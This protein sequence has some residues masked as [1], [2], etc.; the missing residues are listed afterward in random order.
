MLEPGA[1]FFMLDMGGGWERVCYQPRFPAGAKT[2]DVFPSAVSAR[3]FG[4]GGYLTGTAAGKQ[5]PSVL[6]LEMSRWHSCIYYSIPD[7]VSISSLVPS[8]PVKHTVEGVV[9]RGA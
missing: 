1:K 5:I 2:P 7:R 8:P 6:V 3:Y 9:D 4:G